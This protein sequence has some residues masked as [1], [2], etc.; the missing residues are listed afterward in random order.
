MGFRKLKTLL[1]AAALAF[2]SV[3][4]TGIDALAVFAATAAFVDAQT[5]G[6]AR[7]FMPQS[8]ELQ[9]RRLLAYLILEVCQE[10]LIPKT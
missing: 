7:Q 9:L 2:T 6:P 10:V 5:G 3:V 8:V 4:P 1:L